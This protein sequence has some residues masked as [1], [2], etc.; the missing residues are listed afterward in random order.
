MSSTYWPTLRAKIFCVGHTFHHT[1][2]VLEYPVDRPRNKQR[3]GLMKSSEST[4][5]NFWD[6]FDRHVN[7]NCPQHIIEDWELLWP[8]KE[9][10]KR[11]EDWASTQTT[12]SVFNLKFGHEEEV[13]TSKTPQLPKMD[14]KKHIRVPN[15]EDMENVRPDQADDVT[16]EPER[17]RMRIDK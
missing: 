13:A 7:D 3:I 1:L 4:L 8:R 2:D 16:A 12:G 5:D 17:P 9:D 15:S 6:S 11:T 10:L 14:K